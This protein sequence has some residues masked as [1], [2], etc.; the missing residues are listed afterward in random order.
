MKTSKAPLLYI[1]QMYNF[2]KQPPPNKT[3][4]KSA[5]K[6]T[7]KASPPQKNVMKK[8]Q[9]FNSHHKTAFKT[10]TNPK[11]SKEVWKDLPTDF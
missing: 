1:V 7:K 8:I 3:P 11:P 10:P 6:Q 2:V 5:K 9:N 4:M